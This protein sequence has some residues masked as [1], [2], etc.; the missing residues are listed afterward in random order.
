MTAT[1]ESTNIPKHLAELGQDEQGHHSVTSIRDLSSEEIKE[2]EDADDLV[3]KAGN[4][5]AWQRAHHLFAVTMDAIANLQEADPPG[6]G[7]IERVRAAAGSLAIALAVLAKELEGNVQ[8]Y[9]AKE[10]QGDF[11]EQAEEIRNSDTWRLVSEIADKDAGSFKAAPTGTVW[12][13]ASDG[14]VL[15]VP[16]T[17]LEAIRAGQDLLAHHYRAIEP[18]VTEAAKLLLS[19]KAEA[20]GGIP[21]IVE[22]AIEGDTP[23][24]LKPRQLALGRIGPAMR[25]A[26]MSSRLAEQEEVIEQ[27]GEEAEAEPEMTAKPK[28]AGEAADSGEDA[29]GDGGTG[30]D[31]A[32]E[33]GIETGQEPVELSSLFALARTLDGDLEKAWSAALDEALA[34]PAIEK[35]LAAVYS[36]VSALQRNL[37]RQAQE[38]AS[39]GVDSRME[40]WPLSEG[41]LAAL[42]PAPDTE[43]RSKQSGLAQLNAFLDVMEIFQ[44]LQKPANIT[45]S[46]NQEGESV[47]RF[48][49]AGAFALLKDR[50]W[51]LERLTREQDRDVAAAIAPQEAESRGGPPAADLGDA[52]DRLRLGTRALTH[53]DPEAAIF[54]GLLAVARALGVPS[55]GI[56]GKLAEDPGEGES[57]LS[58]DEVQ[59]LTMAIGV[60][61]QSQSGA[62]GLPVATLLAKATLRAAHKLTLGPVGGPALSPSEVAD[63]IE[64]RQPL[65]S[66]EPEE[67]DG[68]G[69]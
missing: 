28:A 51:L 60:V 19:V 65:R 11:S 45:V 59:I 53:G 68:G 16:G 5:A 55:D 38:M 47:E 64:S 40:E 31:P 22:F 41:R 46:F 7:E 8:A 54:H 23:T 43:E 50:L 14:A 3:I 39:A 52:F 18:A 37:S 62:P 21:A 9:G 12:Q 48:W 35:Q 25:A 69:A 42:N 33:E 20:P 10:V 36:L 44:G 17:A 6:P 24:N 27:G 2:I 26:R 4:A 15:N 1:N 66:L 57:R 61:A 30:K 49:S 13:R 32:S 29:A 67:G 58:E 63:L 56:A 34:A